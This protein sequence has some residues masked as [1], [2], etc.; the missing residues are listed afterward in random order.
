MSF[1]LS[2]LSGPPHIS[3]HV[4]HAVVMRQRL[5][6][7]LL[8][9]GTVGIVFFSVIDPG[10]GARSVLTP[11]APLAHLVAYFCLAA[12]VLVVLHDTRRGHAE[13]ILAA[14]VFGLGMELV[15][16]WLP[17]RTFGWDDVAVNAIGASLILL[18][19]H[20]DA[21]TWFIEQED[22]FIERLARRWS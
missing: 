5:N 16:G 20:L 3:I 17:Y 4:P 19:H 21:A 2:L 22:R 9:I 14:A 18:D 12:G 8:G 11:V 1:P 10:T 7:L 6:Q 13:A 15:Q